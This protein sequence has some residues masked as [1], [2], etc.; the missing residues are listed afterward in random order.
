MK[1]LVVSNTAWND[2]YGFGN[3]FSNIFY[4]IKDV[5]F[6]NIYCRKGIPYNDV[7]GRYFQIDEKRLIKS[8][9][10]RSIVTGYE[11]MNLKEKGGVPPIQEH[12]YDFARKMRLRIFY[13]IRDLVWKL[14]NWNTKELNKFVE[15][16]H[17]DVMFLPVYYSTYIN[18]IAV[19]FKRKMNVPMVGYI[20]DDN[21]TLNLTSFS[22]MYW[23]ER[24]YKRRYVKMT[25]D[26]CEFLYVISDIQKEEYAKIF[27]KPSAVLTK[28]MDFIGAPPVKKEVS[29]PVKLIY[30]GNIDTKRGRTLGKIA[31][32][33]DKI[34]MGEIRLTLDIYTKS[35]LQQKIKKGMSGKGVC[36]KGGIDVTEIEQIQLEADV[37][38]HVE[39]MDEKAAKEV[40]QSF[41]TKIVDYLYRARCI[42]AVGNLKCASIDYFKKYKGGL[43]ATSERE[44]EKKAYRNSE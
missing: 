32:C 34:N 25:I 13:W 44:I 6:A 26:A 23:L 17:P 11:V 28:A 1:I 7:K 19:Y 33:V 31:K 9:F 39:P 18:R 10:L 14:G 5:E 38:I 40:H 42:L 30:T 22:P 24:L 8:I 12:Y 29:N 37:L 3:S 2:N 41:S 20:W 15:D 16:F 4:G 43:I 35:P 27:R 21:Y 36:L